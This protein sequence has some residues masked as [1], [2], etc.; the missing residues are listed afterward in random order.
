MKAT[1]LQQQKN[2]TPSQQKS[3]TAPAP[4]ITFA[5]SKSN[6]SSAYSTTSAGLGDKN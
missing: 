4:S 2:R 5:S 3:N 6:T 1:A